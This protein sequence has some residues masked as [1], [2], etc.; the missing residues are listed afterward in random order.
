[1]DN[2]QQEQ[3]NE[4]QQGVQSSHKDIGVIDE[5]T[6][7][8]E[9]QLEEIQSNVDENS[10]DVDELQDKVKRNT[11]ILGGATGGMSMV[12]IWISDKLTRII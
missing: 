1:M 4:I 2:D 5:R 7:N 3:L 9:R 11:T 10:N 6:R 12:L 8:I